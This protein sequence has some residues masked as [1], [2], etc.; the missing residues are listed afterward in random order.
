[1]GASGWRHPLPG[2]G[3]HC[4]S[5]ITVGVILGKRDGGPLG[6]E[7]SSSVG[8]T[9]GMVLGDELS[10][11]VGMPVGM[12]LGGEDRLGLILGDELG[13]KETDGEGDNPQHHDELVLV[14]NQQHQLPNNIRR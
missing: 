10:S 12:V 9:V 4:W 1:M 5:D 11:S 2:M 14:I 6:D 7:L 8:L 13:S 3:R